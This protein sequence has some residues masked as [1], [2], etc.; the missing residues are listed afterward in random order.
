[1]DE[2]LARAVLDLSGRPYAE[3]DLRFRGDRVGALSTQMIPHLLESLVRTSGMTLHL[4]AR[5][6]NDHHVAEAAFKAL[7][8]ALRAAVAVDPAA[9]RRRLD[10]GDAHVSAMA[11]WTGDGVPVAV[12]DYGAGNMVSI[13]G[14]LAAVGADVRVAAKPAGLGGAALV[15]VPG[16]GASAPAMRHLARVGLDV[17]I[18]EA[19]AD[20]VTF[21]GVCLGMQL[22]F[23]RSEEDGA[24]CFG[25]LRGTVEPVPDAPLLPHIG[26]NR[27]E[28]APGAASHPLLAGIEDQ[29]AAYFLH[30]YAAVPADRDMIIATTE[31]GGSFAS[32]VA[33]GRLLG[34]QFHPER[35]GPDGLT[36]LRNAVEFAAA[37]ARD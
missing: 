24:E 16:V 15:V 4:K 12:V 30:T 22:M 19:V 13:A 14:A 34:V 18:R 36:V 21:L 23:E 31:H 10:Q 28:L 20:G 27:L 25:F 6:R 7:A 8:R 26:W 1:M 2:A 33:S 9:L 17:A 29:T 37:A 11:T 32:A 3:L 5:G 35:S